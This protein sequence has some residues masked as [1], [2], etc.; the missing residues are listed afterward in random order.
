MNF[1]RSNVHGQGPELNDVAR[2]TKTICDLGNVSE[3]QTFRHGN[4]AAVNVW[5]HLHSKYANAKLLKNNETGAVDRA[6]DRAVDGADKKLPTVNI[7][8]LKKNQKFYLPRQ[9]DVRSDQLYRGQLSPEQTKAMIDIAKRL[10][11]FHYQ[12]ILNEG[13]KSL[14]LLP[15][16]A[17]SPIT[18]NLG[19]QITPQLLELTARVIQKPSCL[20]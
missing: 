17:K 11:E 5:K 15:N 19:M 18:T 8:Q 14:R 10:L 2:R 6:V 3:M 4:D 20:Y 13:L 16:Q 9:R 1:Y 12:A 7:G